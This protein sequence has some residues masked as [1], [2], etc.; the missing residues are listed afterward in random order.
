[1]EYQELLDYIY[2]RYSGNVKLGLE[3]IF[4]LMEL[5]DYPNNKIEGFHVGGTNGKGS[6]C[7]TL[8]AIALAHDFTT[9]FN[10]SPHLVDYMERFRINGHNID[11]QEV[12]ATYKKWESAY[13]KTD[14]SFF[15]ITTSMAFDIFATHKVDVSMIEVGLGGRLDG[16]QPFNSTVSV[17]TSIGLDHVKSLGGTIPEIAYEKAGILRADVPLVTGDIQPEG[18]EVIENRVDKLSIPHYKYNKDFLVSNIHLDAEG[19]H[20]DYEFPKFNIKLK[21]MTMNLLGRHQAINAAVAV[22]SFIIYMQIKDKDWNEESLRK[23]LSEVNWQGRMQII[24][25]KPLVILDGAHNTEGLIYLINNMKEIFPGRR[26]KFLTAILRDKPYPFM[27]NSM[28]KIADEFVISQSNANRS[29]EVEE[30]IP[31]V[32]KTGVPFHAE[33]DLVKGAKYL[34]GKSTDDDIIIVCGSLYTVAEVIKARD[35]LFG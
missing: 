26:F 23:G 16:T 31:V 6:T 35:D 27:I 21:N 7:A 10:S 18:M 29:A 22:T 34:L 11:F 33:K 9:G 25:K 3:R 1:M 4:Q 24:N 28:A 2:Q 20:F 19:T 32:E 30:L 12:L 14:A 13:D 17:I 8:E 15:E 5:M